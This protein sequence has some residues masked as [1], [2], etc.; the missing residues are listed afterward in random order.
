M[1]STHLRGRSQTGRD[2]RA[3]HRLKE[4]VSLA[5][6]TAA[7]TTALLSP[8]A[9]AEP[10][11][12]DTERVDVQTPGEKTSS[13][14]PGSSF[15]EYAPQL[16][17]PMS[18]DIARGVIRAPQGSS[19]LVPHNAIVLP[20]ELIPVGPTGPTGPRTV[21]DFLSLGAVVSDYL[22]DEVSVRN[23][24]NLMSPERRRL[25]GHVL[26]QLNSPV[27]E[28]PIDL[29]DDGGRD[30]LI[31]ILG[32]GLNSDGTVPPAVQL[33]L[34]KGLELARRLP[35]ATVMLS[36]GQTP[37]GFVEAESMRDWLLEQGLD[38][39][40]IVVEGRS[41]STVSNAW[42][43]RRVADA[44][45]VSYSR[46]VVVVTN[47]FHLHR[48]VTDYTITFGDNARVY[49]APGGSPIAW[50]AQEQRKKAYRDAIASFATPYA[51]I[52]D[53]AIPFGSEVARPF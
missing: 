16:S 44:F 49:G 15:L 46:G 17:S 10:G 1:K 8:A 6:T 52:A 34:E 20:P 53:G 19:D 5:A 11:L 42:H 26:H 29:D 39:N 2:R 31:V 36:G 37:S 45:N 18:S 40:R 35:Q 51:I 3:S 22:G 24:L 32:G 27:V 21:D 9:A 23:W 25:M 47:D 48:A 12:A 43:S 28:P 41:W 30:I 7:V 4:S 50:S 33:R 38:R 14:Y 13:F